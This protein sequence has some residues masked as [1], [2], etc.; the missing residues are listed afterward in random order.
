MI[1]ITG[2]LDQIAVLGEIREFLDAG[3]YKETDIVVSDGTVLHAWLNRC[4]TWIFEV[5]NVGRLYKSIT[6]NNRVVNFSRGIQIV[7]VGD[8][9]YALKK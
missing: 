4:D 7:A 8:F 2:K 9:D 3:F 1:S 6:H 5:R